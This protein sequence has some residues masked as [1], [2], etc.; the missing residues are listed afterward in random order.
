MNNRT[1]KQD[2]A[3]RQKIAPTEVHPSQNQF[4][5]KGRPKRFQIYQKLRI[6]KLTNYLCTKEDQ[7]RR[8]ENPNREVVKRGGKGYSADMRCHLVRRSN[9]LQ[10][11]EPSRPHCCR[12]VLRDCRF[13][14][15]LR[16]AAYVV[17]AMAH[18]L[19]S[20][21]FFSIP[22]HDPLPP[23]WNTDVISGDTPV[24]PLSPIFASQ[25]RI[26]LRGRRQINSLQRSQNGN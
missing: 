19:H 17:A 24:R 8:K 25:Q 3:K 15:P 18:L 10:H 7:R 21:R 16:P 5:A 6:Q 13:P 20:L 22:L 12:C 14:V 23:H 26:N 11:R 4:F 2:K 1:S 9:Q